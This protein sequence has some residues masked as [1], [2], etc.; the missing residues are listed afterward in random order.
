MGHVR[1]RWK[2]PTRR[3]KGLRWQVKYR[4]DGAERDGGSFRTKAMAE[5]RLVELESSVQRGQ[6]VDPTDTTTVADLVRAYV[7]TRQHRRRTADRVDSD[8]RNHIENT[9]LGARRVVS[10]RPSE[11]QA[12]V[13]GRAEVLSP[14]TVRNLAGVLR[15]ALDAAVLDRVV[16]VSPFQKIALPR[17]ERER[18]V[19]LTP[20]QVVAIHDAIG[21]RYRAMVLAQAGLGLRIGEL[22]ALR[23]EDVDFLRRT[24]RVEH[25]IDRGTRERVDPKTPRSR[26]TIPMPDLVA[27]AL[28]AHLAQF[29][30]NHDGLLFHTSTGMPIDHDWYANKVFARAVATVRASLATEAAAA[31]EQGVEPPLLLPAGVT[32]HD[33]RHHYASVLLEAGAS[34]IVVAELLGHENA[35]LVLTT[36]GHLMPGGEQVARRAVDGRYSALQTAEHDSPAAQTRPG[37]S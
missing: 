26:R 34:P 31:V 28:A 21:P 37:G 27:H 17:I 24:A 30:P 20:E 6:W 35:T 3:G 19:P 12:W 9:P 29:D 1:D 13:S 22:L 5:R 11:V 32:T 18:M 14:R 16:P 36:Y 25:Q 4:V 10:V 7:T 8:I 23:V 15:A 33:L 2:D